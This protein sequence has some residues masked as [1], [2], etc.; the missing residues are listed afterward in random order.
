MTSVPVP[1]NLQC[2]VD[3][4]RQF[5]YTDSGG[6]P[7]ALTSPR[8]EVRASQD[9]AAALLYTSEG[10]SPTIVI[11]QPTANTVLATFPASSTM[12][13]LRPEYGYWD[14]YALDP[15]GQRVQLGSG[16]FSS[17]PNVSLLP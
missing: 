5:V 17:T 15:Q 16:S 13:K 3:Y 12:N 4:W 8:M 1:L 11:T 9:S 2:G 6:S 10:V 7:I 14:A